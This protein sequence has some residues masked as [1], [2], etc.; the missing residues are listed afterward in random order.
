MDL[1]FHITR[2]LHIV[3]TSENMTQWRIN[4]IFP[5]TTYAILLTSFELREMNLR[6][7]VAQ[8]SDGVLVK[9]ILILLRKKTNTR[10]FVLRFQFHLNIAIFIW[11]P[12]YVI[13]LEQNWRYN[14]VATQISHN[15]VFTAISYT[16]KHLL[17]SENRA[18]TASHSTSSSS[19]L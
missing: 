10:R 12:I 5:L 11:N 14:S 16:V 7:L 18:I 13:L 19:M 2:V 9:D 17:P 15:A 4:S 8:P 1:K 3:G 6:W